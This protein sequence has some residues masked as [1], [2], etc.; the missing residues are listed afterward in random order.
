MDGAALGGRGRSFLRCLKGGSQKSSCD[1]SGVSI[2]VL[3]YFVD[4]TLT[5]GE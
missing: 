5:C 1:G 3:V 2:F 4:E